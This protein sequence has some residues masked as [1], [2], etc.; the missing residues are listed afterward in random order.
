MPVISGLTYTVTDTTI[1]AVWT[2]DVSADSN[3]SA[4]GK[5]AID[6]GLAASATSHQCIVT[7]LTQNTLYSCFVTSGG[8]SSTPQNV[9]TGAAKV[10]TP[11][12]FAYFGLGTDEPQPAPNHGDAHY[13]FVSSDNKTYITECDGYGFV[14]GTPNAGA[15]MQLCVLTN[16]A[17]SSFNG[18]LVNLLT[19]YG[20]FNTTSGTDG[21]G[22]TA[23]TNKLTGIFGMLGNLYVFCGRQDTTGGGA[24]IWYNNV[25]KSTDHGATWNNYQAPSTF[26]AA[27]SPINTATFPLAQKTYGWVSPILYGPDDGTLGYNSAGNQIDGANG[28]VYCSFVVSAF[29]SGAAQTSPG[30][31]LRVPRIQ[32]DSGQLSTGVQYWIGPTNPA[33]TD[34]VNDAN[35]SSSDASKTASFQPAS[36]TAWPIITFL[37]GV[38]RY[39]LVS[40][41]GSGA[42]YVSNFWEAPTPAG[43]WTQIYTD[44]PNGNPQQFYGFMPMHRDWTTNA[45]TDNIAIRVVYSGAG[46][47]ST[48]NAYYYPTV[49]TLILRTSG[50]PN[51]FIQGN[52]DA[53]GGGVA[54]PYQI[55]FPGNVTK[56]D[57]LIIAVR[58]GTEAVSITSVNGTLNT[59]NWNI[60]YQTNNGGIIGAWAWTISVGSGA[61]T[62]KVTYNSAPSTNGTIGCIAEYRGANTLRVAGAAN[63]QT[64]TTSPVSNSI[65]SVAGD[66]VLGLFCINTGSTFA[67]TGGYNTREVGKGGDLNT[68]G[69]IADSLSSLGGATTVTGSVTTLSATTVGIGAF[70]FVAPPVTG[71][72]GFGGG[73]AGMGASSDFGYRF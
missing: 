37:P 11:I 27:G 31:L 3:L 1:V 33:P 59:Q 60:V 61:E 38:N 2:T 4:G 63:A 40:E 62:V 6:N 41:R 57:L 73:A 55:A 17:T 58:F 65:T 56:G 19:A 34:F 43:P 66:L 8:T 15:N 48:F 51:T 30:Y 44:A 49:S 54:N 28:F 50:V 7:G 29:S 12:K 20:G 45:A 22:A 70:Y 35:W 46:L 16:E 10:R 68:Y 23:L 26:N 67:A 14:S 47:N 69:A 64:S 71:G 72:G 9:T 52:A 42:N 36:A 25:I 21:P 18:T 5:N 13:T 32:F 39:V 53:A 24:G